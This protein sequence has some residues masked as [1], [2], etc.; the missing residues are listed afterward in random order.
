MD[1]DVYVES[2]PYGVVVVMLAANWCRFVWDE[3]IL[4]MSDMLFIMSIMTIQKYDF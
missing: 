3:A 1:T 4:F 2:Y